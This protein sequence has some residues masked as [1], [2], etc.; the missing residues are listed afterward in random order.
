MTATVQNTRKHSSLK[1]ILYSTL[2]SLVL[3][4]ALL[5]LS[6]WLLEKIPKSERFE[7]YFVL[8]VQIFSGFLGGWV[9]SRS[10]QNCLVRSIG[11][12]ALFAGVMFLLSLLLLNVSALTAFVSVLPVIPAGVCGGCL[13][14][15][16]KS[17]KRKTRL[18]KR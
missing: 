10:K 12:S 1:T 6:V 3:A 15:M 8:G 13:N 16:R 9:S 14:A 11:T 2:L 7:P 5:A 18:K 17:G 4:F